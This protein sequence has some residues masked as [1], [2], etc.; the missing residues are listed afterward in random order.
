MHKDDTMNIS[1]VLG[2]DEKGVQIG[3]RIKRALEDAGFTIGWD[4]SIKT[5][6]L[7]KGIKWQRRA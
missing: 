3:H 2:D 6:L 5:R 7:V 1:D 4:D